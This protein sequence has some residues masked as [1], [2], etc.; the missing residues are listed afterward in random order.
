MDIFQSLKEERGITIVLI[1]HE[2]DVAAYG[3]RIISFKDGVIVSDALNERRRT[4]RGELADLP[5]PVEE[6]A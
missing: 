6:I 2:H 1:T 5:L 4:A 3:S